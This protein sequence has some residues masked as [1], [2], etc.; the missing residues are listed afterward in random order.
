MKSNRHWKD[1]EYY[2]YVPSSGLIE[3]SSYTEIFHDQEQYGN[4]TSAT[5]NSTLLGLENTFS[6]GFE[7]NHTTFQHNNNSPYSGTS[8]VDPFNFDPG[9]FINTA[10]TLPKYRSQA[11]Q[12]AFFAEDRLA[13]TKRWSIVS[14]L[15]YDHA[16]VNRDDLVTGAAF[17]N[18][19]APSKNGHEVTLKF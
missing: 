11:N 12:Y 3:R 9:S 15:R 18:G 4:V 6:T 5:L 7:F 2:T 8:F 13:L 16:S 14:G 1:A 10:G 19:L 17:T